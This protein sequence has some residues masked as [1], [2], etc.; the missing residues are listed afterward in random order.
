[1]DQQKLI[2]ERAKEPEL[3]NAREIKCTLYGKIEDK[4]EIYEEYIVQPGDT[5]LSIAKNKLGTVSRIGDLVYINEKDFP[6]LSIKNP[7]I[8]PGWI[9]HL[10]PSYV[11]TINF[12]GTVPKLIFGWGGELVEITEDG[13]W[14]VDGPNVNQRYG[15]KPDAKTQFFGKSKE[16][17]VIGDCVKA[18]LEEYD[19]RVFAV[20][21]Q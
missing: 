15:F 18:L 4:G 3:N 14:I 5:L 9:I 2:L 21:L 8:E 6:G 12:S 19:L 11:E 7:Y 16:G 13:Q 20:H 1:M 10:P 17:F